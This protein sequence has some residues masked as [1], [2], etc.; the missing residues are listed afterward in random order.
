ML[1]ELRTCSFAK[2][3]GEFHL[4]LDHIPN[5]PFLKNI[6]NKNNLYREGFFVC[7]F[8]Y[9]FKVILH[10]GLCFHINNRELALA[11]S[12]F[13]RH[14]LKLILISLHITPTIFNLFLEFFSKD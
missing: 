6:Q 11:F 4:I 10:P 14:K 8:V 13:L 3:I 5:I 2:I 1:I 12:V 7:C 9:Y